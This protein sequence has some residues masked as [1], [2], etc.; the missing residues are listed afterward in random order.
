MECRLAGEIEVLGENLPQRQFCP[1]QNPTWPDPGLNPGRRGGKPDTNRL[2]YGASFVKK[3]KRD[4]IIL[5]HLGPLERIMSVTELL[6]FVLPLV[7]S[8]FFFKYNMWSTGTVFLIRWL[9]LAPSTSP[10]NLEP[11]LS[12]TWWPKQLYFRKC[13]I[14]DISKEWTIS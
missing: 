12:Y 14:L 9:R 2:S 7:L 3:L 1:S 8:C 13:P 4:G 10:N 5:I 6:F 11:F